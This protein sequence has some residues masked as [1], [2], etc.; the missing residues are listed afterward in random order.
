MSV[1]R[2]FLGTVIGITLGA[3]LAP[4]AHFITPIKYLIF[5]LMSVIK[6]TPV[7]SFIVLLLILTGKEIVPTV[8]AALIALPI[9]HSNVSHGIESIDKSLS[10]VCTVFSLGFFKRFK[11]LWF[12]SVMPS[13]IAGM[14]SCIGLSWK[15]GIAAEVLCTPVQSIGYKINETRIY[16]ETPELFA[17]TAVVIIL[18]F[19]IEKIS[20]L[21]FSERRGK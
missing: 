14:K 11:V 10:E 15:A 6:A 7:A 4:T 5:P 12:P 16:L 3:I 8:T 21:I 1:A 19:A 13:F 9:V 17:W 18:S 20:L 2:I